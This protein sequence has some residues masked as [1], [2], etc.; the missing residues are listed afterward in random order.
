VYAVRNALEA[1]RLLEFEPFD[2]MVSEWSERGEF[3]AVEFYD[4]ICRFWPDLS[5]RIIFVI[6]GT[7]EIESA[8]ARIRKSCVFLRK[9]FQVDELLTAVQQVLRENAATQIKH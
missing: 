4:W 8:P 1:V 7:G 9:P 2:L 6:S 3:P 5:K